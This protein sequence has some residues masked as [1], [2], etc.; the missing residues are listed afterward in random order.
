MTTGPDT[1]APRMLAPDEVRLTRDSSDNV[2]AAIGGETVAVKRVAAA[3]PLT[4]PLRM[5]NIFDDEGSLVGIITDTRGMD[6]ASSR[7]LAEELEKAYFMPT[8]MDIFAID[9]KMGVESWDV[10]T[11]KGPRIFQVHAPRRNIRKLS[12]TRL[13]IRDVDSNR[14]EI[15]NWTNLPQPA[16]G[17][18]A[19]HL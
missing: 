2:K 18:I 19:R 10:Q 5:V 7:I 4:G 1:T 14:Y 9:E 3:F 8:V 11:S 15:R 13:I 16:Q 17:L 12:P 6:G